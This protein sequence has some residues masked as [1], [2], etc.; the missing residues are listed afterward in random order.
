MVGMASRITG[1]IFSGVEWEDDPIFHGGKTKPLKQSLV[2][3]SEN[4]PVIH[5]YTSSTSYTLVQ[6]YQLYQVHIRRF[7]S[8]LL[9]GRQGIFIFHLPSLACSEPAVLRITLEPGGLIVTSWWVIPKSNHGVFDFN[10]LRT[11]LNSWNLG[12]VSVKYL[13][14][15]MQKKA[16]NIHD[17]QQ[18]NI[19]DCKFDPFWDYWIAPTN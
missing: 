8:H 9:Q 3:G 7:A 15:C 19:A 13:V 14:I 1:A 10:C 18:T 4:I 16:V 6:I 12:K 5:S 11:C 17:P 2:F